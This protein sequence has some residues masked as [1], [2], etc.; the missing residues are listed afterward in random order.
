M[1]RIQLL[2]HKKKSKIWILII[3]DIILVLA[4]LGVW[5]G[6]FVASK[7]SNLT[8]KPLDKSVR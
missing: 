7:L 1:R 8:F 5:A 2:K 4:F 6:S 3:I